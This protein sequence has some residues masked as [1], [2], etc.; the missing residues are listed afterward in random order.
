MNDSH[1]WP[2]LFMTVAQLVVF[3]CQLTLQHLGISAM[4]VFHIYI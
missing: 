2:V 3:P 4:E 1:I